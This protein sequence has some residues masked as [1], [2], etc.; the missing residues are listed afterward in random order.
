[1]GVSRTVS[2]LKHDHSTCGVLSCLKNFR[3]Q[4]HDRQLTQWLEKRACGDKRALEHKGLCHDVFIPHLLEVTSLEHSH[5]CLDLRVKPC[6]KGVE[7]FTLLLK[8]VK[9]CAVSKLGTCLRQ[10]DTSLVI[11]HQ[12]TSRDKDVDLILFEEQYIFFMD[13]LKLHFVYHLT[14]S[15]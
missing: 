1:M 3:D 8:E 10:I 4:R 5:L 7:Q 12:N 11:F 2:R 6:F 9:Y 13:Q 14:Y 15:L